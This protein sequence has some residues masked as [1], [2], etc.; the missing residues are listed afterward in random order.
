MHEIPETMAQVTALVDQSRQNGQPLTEEQV[1][2]GGLQNWMQEL[3]DEGI[4]GGYLT[5]QLTD[6]GLTVL[7]I[8]GKLLLKTDTLTAAKLVPAFKQDPHMTLMNVQTAMRKIIDSG[9][10]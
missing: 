4:E 8:T 9:R 5:A 3:L 7:D 10:L 2:Q 1:I 6:S